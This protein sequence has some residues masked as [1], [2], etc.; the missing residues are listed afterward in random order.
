MPTSKQKT[1]SEMIHRST[2]EDRFE[3]VNLHGR[4]G[5]LT[6]GSFRY[7]NQKFYTSKEW[8]DFRNMIIERDLGCD[9]AIP[10]RQIYGKIVLHH[11]EPL[12]V[13]MVMEHSD[14][15]MEPDNVVCVSLATH[16]AIHYGCF[17]NAPQD[18][19]PRR[20]GDTTP[21]KRGTHV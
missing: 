18:F 6:Y 12:T 10:D 11:I 16:N 3:Y 20:P 4:V 17:E 8:R 9:L 2:F 19:E 5:E 7:L 14:L 15:L 1:Y 21:W 13:E